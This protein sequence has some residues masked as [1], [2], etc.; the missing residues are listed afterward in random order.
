MSLGELCL[1][2]GVPKRTL[3]LGFGELFGLSPVAYH[4]K[5]ASQCGAT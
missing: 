5:D 2:T 4:R 3:M 1:A